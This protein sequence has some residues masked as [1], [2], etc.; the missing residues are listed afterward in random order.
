VEV[1]MEKKL[2]TYDAV[3]ALLGVQKGTLY[4]WVNQRKIP[5]VKLGARIVR[6]D[7]AQLA[8]WMAA[9]SVVAEV[10]DASR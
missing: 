10:F 3:A 6:F 2:L 1:K 9:R 7:P 4:Y 5:H 8:A